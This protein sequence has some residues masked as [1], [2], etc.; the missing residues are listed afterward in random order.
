MR[1]LL[2][3]STLFV[4]DAF[5]AQALA[6]A[7]VRAESGDRLMADA[8]TRARTHGR[9]TQDLAGAPQLLNRYQNASPAA[10]AV[11]EAAMDARRLGVGLHLPQAFLTDAA[12]D[13]LDQ[14]DYDQLTDDLG[15]AG[16]RRTGRGGPRQTSPVAQYH[17]Q[18]PTTAAGALPTR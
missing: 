13:Y 10:K 17:P 5:D 18:A 3:G 4:P 11:L 15:R 1:E 16:L 2:A 9:V 8:L 14:S 6:A 12:I 7:A